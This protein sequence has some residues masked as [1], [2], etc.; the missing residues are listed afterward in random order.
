MKGPDYRPGTRLNLGG[1][2]A[3]VRLPQQLQR[4]GAE[5]PVKA[6]KPNCLQNGGGDA[7]GD[8]GS[9][10]E[11]ASRQVLGVAVVLTHPASNNHTIHDCFAAR[12]CCSIKQYSGR[13]VSCRLFV[14]LFEHSGS[15]LA[16]LKGQLEV[17][18]ERQGELEEENKVISRRSYRR[19]MC[20]RQCVFHRF[21]A[22]A[23]FAVEGENGGV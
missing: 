15:E 14:I 19:I 21:S 9:I 7:G 8:G 11:S 5:P 22:G 20:H 23:H 17:A 13:S 6:I 1:S 2:L 10:V 18:L 4:A 3:I 12:C 16:T